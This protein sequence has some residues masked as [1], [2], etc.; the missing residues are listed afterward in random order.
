[1][2]VSFAG[3]YIAGSFLCIFL[4]S[5]P[6]FLPPSQAAGINVQCLPG[7]LRTT[8]HSPMKHCLTCHSADHPFL[9][10]SPYRPPSTFLFYLAP[11]SAALTWTRAKVLSLSTGT[12]F[13]YYLSLCVCF[14]VDNHYHCYHGFFFYLHRFFHAPPIKYVILFICTSPIPQFYAN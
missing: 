13:N 11:T 1:M 8:L 7:R 6:P 2:S 10:L 3:L 5:L 9:L 14:Q 12:C 4:S